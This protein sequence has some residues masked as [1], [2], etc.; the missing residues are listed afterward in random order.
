MRTGQTGRMEQAA[1]QTQPAIRLG[2]R[3]RHP[4]APPY[5]YTGAPAAVGGLAV[6]WTLRRGLR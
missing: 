2:E 3:G 5:A 4:Q 6:G 1:G